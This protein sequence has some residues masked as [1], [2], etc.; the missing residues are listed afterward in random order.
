MILYFAN[1]KMDIL[2]HATTNLQKGYVITE[3][4]KTE[5]IETGIATFSCRVAFDKDTRLTLEDMTEAGNYLLRSHNGENEFYTIIDSEIDTKNQDIYIYAEDAGLDLINE[6]VDAYEAPAS[7]T[8]EWYINKYLVDSGFEIGINEIPS[9]TKKQLSWSG[10]SS[11]T[12]RLASIATEFGGY[13]ISYSFD[14]KGL[15]ITNKYVNIY[16]ER[17]KDTGETLRLNRDID[18]I[19]ISKSVANLATAF[20]C[21]GGTPEG[22]DNPITLKGYK[23]D[24]GDFYVGTDGILRSRKAVE[25]WSRY[26]WNKEPNQ[27]S[28]Y[29]GHILKPYSYDTT[30]QATLCSHAV[31]ELK[32]VCDMEVNYDVDIKKL[33]DNVRIGDRI[34]IVDDA[35]ELYVSSRVLKLETSV[36][37]QDYTATL[38]EHLIKSSGISQKVIELAEQFA[39]NAQSAAKALS[40]ATAAKTAAEE[41]QAK[42][43]TAVE[44]AEKATQAANEATTAANTATE[45]AAQAKTAA[46]NAQTAVDNVEKSVEELETTVTN[47]QT[48]ADNAQQAASTAQ[49]KADEAEQAAAQAKA[50]AADAKAAVVV[51]EGK[52]ETAITKAETAQS[53]AE[54]AKTEATT[55]KETAQAAKL[56]AKKAEED[57]ASL[58]ERL[59]TV[60]TT[61]EA[62]YAR[63]TDLTDAKAHLQTQISRNAAGITSTA[64]KVQTIDETTNDAQKQLQ[65]AIKWAETA[66]AMA[67]E[68]EAEANAAQTAADEAEQAANNAQ[69][70]ADTARVAA[71]EA[72]SAAIQAEANLKAAKEEL[73]TISS[74]ADAT[75]EEIA[76]AQAAVDTAQAA[77]NKARDDAASAI[78][79]ANEAQNIADTATASAATA[80]ELANNA[81][82]Q[83]VL[84]QKMADE[85][86]GDA[87][88]AQLKADEAASIAATAQITAET[89]LA[90]ANAAQQTAATAQAAA[91]KAAQIA[92]EAEEKAAQA[93]S[94]LAAA[95]QN[96][97]DV[98][99]RVDAT[100]EEVAA[101]EEA[102]SAAQAA[103]E[104]A[105]TE[106][107]AAQA[108]ANAARIDADNAQAAADA[109]RTEADKAQL[110]AE[111]AEV[112]ANEAALAVS[113]LAVR[114]VTAETQIKQTSDALELRATKTEVADYVDGIEFGGRNLLKGTAERITT[115]SPDD[116]DYQYVTYIPTVLPL[117]AGHPYTISAKVDVLAGD[118]T[119]ISVKLY[120]AELQTQY[121]EVIPQIT[122]GRIVATF[123]TL[124]ATSAERVLLYAGAAGNTAGNS[125]AFSEV[126]LEK[127]NKATDW[128]EAP[129]D[130]KQTTEAAIKL[131]SD[132][133][134]LKFT[135]QIGAAED[136][137]NERLNTIEKHFV[138]GTDGMEVKAE[139]SDNSVV[140]DNDEISINVKGNPVQTFDAEGNADIPSLV[141]GRQFNLLGLVITAT[142][143]AAGNVTHISGEFVGGN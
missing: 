99:G 137:A 138:F 26:V 37:D 135:K 47:A 27:L 8:A 118:V 56:D 53:T 60:T 105:N 59:T 9:S 71:D 112:A 58:G 28:G 11:V 45:S 88:E 82:Q 102:V 36:V 140:I 69:A 79:V 61:M 17:G 19:I 13:E 72:Q 92:N 115:T 15:A 111:E 38:G 100:E 12:E 113:G 29:A 96:L 123:P 139:G 125:V 122:N 5:E 49:T 143:D 120:D 3:D 94:D 133:L 84:A 2:G 50:D 130:T 142:T 89:A 54:T 103:A 98:M 10:E 44:D 128:T 141:V 1:R 62:D 23:Y 67:D 64:S 95:Q 70:E 117:E 104:R 16:K 80:R 68:A 66:R 75:E 81:A 52:A 129:E 131:M 77:V 33:P 41:A 109:A 65:G 14:I 22:A 21:E 132:N 30:S 86:D 31:T 124:S 63:K 7:Y 39:K 20:V 55:A 121:A 48:A 57:I 110:A 40:V 87:T 127:G 46:D 32:K 43:D 6:I 85:A 78:S 83:A 93:A 4:L 34:N 18:K 119:E 134:D 108:E 136:S 91:N 35:G 101:A 25:K 42:A 114:M 116:Y 106:A 74:K 24:D 76:A 90:E 107:E 51:A 97:T 73:A 126:K